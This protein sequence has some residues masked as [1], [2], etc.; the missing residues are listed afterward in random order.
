M[1]STFTVCKHL[2]DGY[3]LYDFLEYAGVLPYSVQL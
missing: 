3:H 1:S 2:H